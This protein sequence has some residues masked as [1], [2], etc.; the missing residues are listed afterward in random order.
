MKN[1][2]AVYTDLGMEEDKGL[3]LGDQAG[4]GERGSG[5]GGGGGETGFPTRRT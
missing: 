3:D 2:S 1:S 4:F 5:G